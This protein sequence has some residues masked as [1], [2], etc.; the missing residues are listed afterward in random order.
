MLARRSVY[1][2]SG[3][4]AGLCVKTGAGALLPPSF[5]FFYHGHIYT[6]SFADEITGSNRHNGRPTDPALII[7]LTLEWL[8]R[9]Y[10]ILKDRGLEAARSYAVGCIDQRRDGRRQALHTEHP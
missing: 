8:E 10:S 7:D 5:V 2:C 6:R 1:M 4:V 3:R 9:Y